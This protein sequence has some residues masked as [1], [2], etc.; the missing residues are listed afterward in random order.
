MR[1]A[2]RRHHADIAP[3][4]PRA[5]YVVPP[6]FRAIS[7]QSTPVPR[8]ELVGPARSHPFEPVAPI[9]PRPHTLRAGDSI[10]P[11]PDEL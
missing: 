10:S 7:Q 6:N 8:R 4:A 9:A 2:A 3:A 11:V 5:G 1:G